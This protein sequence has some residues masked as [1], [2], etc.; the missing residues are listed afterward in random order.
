M[1]AIVFKNIR[2]VE[3]ITLEDPK[4][5][6]PTDVILKMEA[7]GICGSDLHPYHGRELGLDAGTVMGHEGAGSVIAIGSAVRNFKIGDRAFAPFTTNCGTCAYCRMGLTCRCTQGQ[8]FGWRQNQVGLHGLQ[9]EFARIPLADS[10]LVKVPEGVKAEEAVLLG[11]VVA[12][13]YHAAFLCAEVKTLGPSP[14]TCVV[15]LG[16]VGLSAI[17]GARQLG[18]EKIIALDPLPERRQLAQD[19]GATSFWG[20]NEEIL[21]FIRD[22]TLGLGVDSCIEAVGAPAPLKLAYQVLRAGGCLAVPGVHPEKELVL[23]PPELYDKNLTF[24]TGRT[25][26]RFYMN[27]LLTWVTEKKLPILSLVSHLLPLS[28][29]VRAYQLFDEKIDGCTKVILNP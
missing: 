20:S 25:P 16:P 1:K 22:Q 13:G 3:V 28:E 2:Q 19:L 24:R 11:D 12:T 7:C 9:A 27:S 8:L 23:T 29:G 6:E 10:T 18:A 17:L 21:G 4:L 15:G 14:W 26:A 5:L